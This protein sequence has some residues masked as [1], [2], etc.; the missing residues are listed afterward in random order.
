MDG[1]S[2]KP[3]K[4]EGINESINSILKPLD[5]TQDCARLAPLEQQFSTF[6]L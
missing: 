5:E 4:N 1:Q 2:N 6:G 3:F